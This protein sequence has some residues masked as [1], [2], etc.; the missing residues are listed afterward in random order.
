MIH[1]LQRLA[2]LAA[3]LFPWHAASAQPLPLESIGRTSVGGRPESVIGDLDYLYASNLGN[4]DTFAKDG[5]GYISKLSYDG[6]LISETFL[7]LPEALDGPTGMAFQGDRLYVADL[8]EVIGFDLAGQADPARID[9]RDFGV[10]FLND[11][12]A[13]SDRHLVVSGTNVKKL[14]LVDTVAASAEP[15]ELDFELNHPN[16]LAYDD[17]SGLLYVAANLVHT[18][19]SNASNGEVLKLDLNVANAAASF[20]SKASEAGLFLDGIS[21]FG[22]DQLIYSDWVS[23]SR[24]AGVLGRLNLDDLSPADP[25]ELNVSGFADFHWQENRGILAAPNLIGGEVELFQYPIP[26]PTTTC[27]ACFGVAMLLVERRLH[28]LIRF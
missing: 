24:P 19:G 13:V 1:K 3:L 18:I 27:L 15:L 20:V 4:G 17:R 2:F 9:L 6:E 25:T 23:G 16:G 7:S 28:G 5:N 22:D 12:V 14:F 8:D 21:L 11:L 26:E 10:S